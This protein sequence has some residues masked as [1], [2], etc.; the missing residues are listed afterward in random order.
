M[1]DV[2]LLRFFFFRAVLVCFLKSVSL[3]IPRAHATHSSRAVRLYCT[4]M[5]THTQPARIV[6]RVLSPI[7][8]TCMKYRIWPEKLPRVMAL[9]RFGFCWSTG[10]VLCGRAVYHIYGIYGI[11]GILDQIRRYPLILTV[12]VLLIINSENDLFVLLIINSSANTIPE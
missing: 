7:Q 3:G 6:S 11:Y 12:L 5:A 4:D 10:L 8:S 9:S 2:M 1:N